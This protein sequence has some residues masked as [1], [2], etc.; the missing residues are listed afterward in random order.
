MK[1]VRMKGKILLFIFLISVTFFACASKG[2]NA[3]GEKTTNKSEKEIYIETV[4]QFRLQKDSVFKYD[5]QSP[6]PD[7]LRK[8]FEHLNYFELD[9][10]YY[11]IATFRKY[12]N[13]DTLKMLTTKSDDIRTMLRYG[14]FIFKIDGKELRLQGYVNVPP[15]MPMYIFLP[16]TDLTSGEESY[17][18][19][20]YLDIEMKQN[21]KNI[22]LDFNMAYNPYCAYNSRY[23]CPLVPQE[24]FLDIKI[25]AGEKK[26]ANH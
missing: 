19:G 25:K 7:S 14:E 21:E 10:K 13:P 15:D 20:K 16:F 8:N 17:E 2:D 9:T 4:K 11:V 3:G 22:V 23:S 26:Y 12:K 1:C 18:G 24:N 5:A 6:I